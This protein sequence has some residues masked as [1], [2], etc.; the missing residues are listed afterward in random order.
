MNKTKWITIG[1]AAA[2]VSGGLVVAHARAQD[3]GFGHAGSGRFLARAK[4]KL[5]LSDDQVAKIKTVLSADKDPLIKLLTNLHDARV[6]LRETIQ[7]PGAT[8]TDI[9]TA[10]ANVATV[11]ADLALERAKLYGSISPILTAGQLEKIS[12]FESRVD[13]FVD[14]AILLFGKR[15]AE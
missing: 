3:A 5:G 15:L 1:L 11:E 10:A 8:E 9:R 2:L 6:H 7:K 4:S 14:G 13:D 12:D